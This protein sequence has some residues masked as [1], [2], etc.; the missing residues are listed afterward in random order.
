MS[1]MDRAATLAALRA[2]V[3]RME[4]TRLAIED[5]GAVSVCPVV[6]GHLPDGAGLPRGAV[7]D[8]AADEEGSGAA[9]GFV[10]LLAGRAGLTCIWIGPNP[11]V[12]PPGAARYGLPPTSLVLVRAAGADAL[13]AAEEALRCPAVGCT[14]LQAA[15]GVDLTASRRLQ[16]AA[17]AGGGIAL[18]LVAPPALLSP[19]A[20]RTRWR[21][22]PSTGTSR[23]E[24]SL[25]MAAWR[26]ELVKAAGGRPGAWT[27]AVD[28]DRLEPLVLS[29]PEAPAIPTRRRRA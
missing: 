4:R 8:V 29:P 2:R 15:K 5:R 18:V 12:W 9:Y 20:A 6:D 7:H 11:D 17:E 26:V 21:I 25:G 28:A 14:V 16:L 23:V 22:A 19:S 3:S 27:L 10:S 13:W 24:H 1:E